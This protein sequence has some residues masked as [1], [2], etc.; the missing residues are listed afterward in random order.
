MPGGARAVAARRSRRR[1]VRND[2]DGTFSQHVA[3][4][5]AAVVTA[6]VVAS[7]FEPAPPRPDP[8]V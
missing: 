7:E 2:G 6:V 5:Q 1:S 8:V 4:A 3:R